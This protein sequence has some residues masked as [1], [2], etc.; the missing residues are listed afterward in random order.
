MLQLLGS[1][2]GVLQST[3]YKMAHHGAFN[4]G[5]A[6]RIRLLDAVKPKATFA[7]SN[8]WHKLDDRGFFHPRCAVID[9]LKK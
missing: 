6:N 2:K 1:H 3:V 8:P 4:R 9:Y 5:G 7:S